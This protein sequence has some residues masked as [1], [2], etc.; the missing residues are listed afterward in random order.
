LDW[1]YMNA[2]QFGYSGITWWGDKLFLAINGYCQN[3]PISQSDR[4]A[5]LTLRVE[6]RSPSGDLL[7]VIKENQ[8]QWNRDLLHLLH[9]GRITDNTP[10]NPLSPLL[11]EEPLSNSGSNS[12]TGTTQ[13]ALDLEILSSWHNMREH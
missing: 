2:F 10:T 11:S 9:V 4:N 13:Q 7:N 5:E 8:A 1:N 3:G 6:V 12:R